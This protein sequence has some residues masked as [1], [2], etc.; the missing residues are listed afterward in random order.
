MSNVTTIVKDERKETDTGKI[1]T[2]MQKSTIIA[3]PKKTSSTFSTPIV[4]YRIISKDVGL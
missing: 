4:K 3:T 2:S 1:P